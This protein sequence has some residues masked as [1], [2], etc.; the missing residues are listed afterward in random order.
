MV[1]S[2]DG[3]SFA[4][5]GALLE[6]YAVD[7]TAIDRLFSRPEADLDFDR[8]QALART[9][10]R[11][12]DLNLY[13]RIRLPDRT[14]V[15]RLCDALNAL[16]FIELATPARIPAPPPADIPPKTPDYTGWQ[17][18]GHV[19]DIVAAQAQY[20]GADGSGVTIADIEYSWIADHEDIEL[21]PTA[22]L[23]T[24]L[25]QVHENHG[26]AVIGMLAGKANDYGITGLVPEVTLMMVPVATRDR[27]GIADAIN[28]AADALQPGDV[29][30]VE[31]QEYVCDYFE[32]GPVEFYQENYDAIDAATS[33]GVVVIEPAGNGGLDLDSPGCQGLFDRTMRDS[34]AIVVGAGA[35][36]RTR[37]RLSSFGGRVDLQGWG[38]HVA[39]TGYGDL[40]GGGLDKRQRYTRDFCG[41]SAAAAMVAAV[42]AAVQGS[43][44]AR[45]ASELLPRDLRQRL[46]ET[47]RA[48]KHG[49]F[50]GN[51]GPLPVTTQA[52]L[53]DG[54]GR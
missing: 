32:L 1:S 43:L 31:Q 36:D 45:G 14:D 27:H 5:F 28:V 15:A 25:H 2:L 50:R 49:V 18:Y 13:Y 23:G 46:V 8:A 53:V 7:L 47:G 54:R 39:T 24:P 19:I 9:G 22:I 48:Q 33:K 29:L 41:T 35:Q 16:P 40:F 38:R 37:L 4:A 30:L 51:I 20:P 12:A 34:G 10:R 17:V 44:R 3:A 11:L 21:P 42:A 52:L 6:E 26:T